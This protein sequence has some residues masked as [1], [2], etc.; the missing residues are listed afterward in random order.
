MKMLPIIIDSIHAGGGEGILT[1]KNI[2]ELW[3]TIPMVPR[4]F[5][6]GTIGNVLLF[7]MDQYCSKHI[8]P[9]LFEKGPSKLLK[10]LSDSK[11]SV[12]FFIS[13]A[14]QII[15]QHLLNALLVFGLSSI[16]TRKK[17]FETLI[18]TYAT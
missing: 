17:Y 15:I 2:V 13:Y 3:F 8:I 14:A 9:I 7:I 6:S 1:N 12:S 11:E 16:S 4:F 10:H 18:G 5:A